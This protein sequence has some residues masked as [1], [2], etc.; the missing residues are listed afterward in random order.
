MHP[1]I[2]EDLARQLIEERI[3]AG[4]RA[5]LGRRRRRRIPHVLAAA[6]RVVGARP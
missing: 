2:V 6:L 3:A 4:A 1:L 5:R